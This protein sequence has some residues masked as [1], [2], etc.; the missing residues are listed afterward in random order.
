MIVTLRDG[1]K[2]NYP[3]TRETIE[4][5]KAS[6]PA[7]DVDRLLIDMRDLRSPEEAFPSANHVR[8]WIET[9][10]ERKQAEGVAA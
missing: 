4:R 2:R 5:W 1:R 9:N 6:F 3:V 7:V 8:Q 10:A